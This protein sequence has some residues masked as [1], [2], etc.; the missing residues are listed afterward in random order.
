[1]P[2]YEDSEYDDNACPC[3]QCGGFTTDEMLDAF[4]VC[5]ACYI[6]GEIG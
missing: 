4:G 3:P 5:H 2:L 6:E 1:M